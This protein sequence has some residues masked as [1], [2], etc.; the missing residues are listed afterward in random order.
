MLEL[1]TFRHEVKI[2]ARET[3]E[4][5]ERRGKEAK[6]EQRRS[7]TSWRKDTRPSCSIYCS[8]RVSTIIL[9]YIIV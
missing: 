8:L 3:P 5:A 7:W 2:E 9:A 6:A 1:E 4:M